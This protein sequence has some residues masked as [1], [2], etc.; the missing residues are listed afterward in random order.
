MGAGAGRGRQQLRQLIP[1]IAFALIASLVAV[2]Q[3]S[4]QTDTVEYSGR[5]TALNGGTMEGIDLPTNVVELR[6]SSAGLGGK[7]DVTFPGDFSFSSSSGDLCLELDTNLDTAPLAVAVDATGTSAVDSQVSVVVT[8]I[9]SA[10]GG[11][12]LRNAKTEPAQLTATV[13][14]TE[15]NGALAME[16]LRLD[17]AAFTSGTG[18]SSSSSASSSG[19]EEKT[20]L[21][22][23]PLVKDFDL[24]RRAF[25]A[26]TCAFDDFR[27]NSRSKPCEDIQKT[28]DQYRSKLSRRFASEEVAKD[29]GAITI[30]AD[31]RRPNGEFALPSLG[32][33]MRVLAVMA[34][35]ADKGGDE[36]EK[37]Q[38]AL[39]RLVQILVDVDLNAVK[40]K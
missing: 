17:F 18:S 25:G 24:G 36:G 38:V 22:E 6:L 26:S 13:T 10:C 12:G 33:T 21:L 1:F 30:L 34:A 19:D 16:G 32:A 39:R 5:F 15:I 35:N 27:N 37:A 11:N 8:T 23:D 2:Q 7:L 31:L 29:F 3:A 20:T 4:A 40:G 28:L 14:D 9:D